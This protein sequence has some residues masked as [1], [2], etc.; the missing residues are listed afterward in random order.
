MLQLA[1]KDGLCINCLKWGHF[2]KNCMKGPCGE[3][4]VSE[5]T[6]P[7]A[8]L[9]ERVRG[10]GVPRDRDPKGRKE[11]TWGLPREKDSDLSASLVNPKNGLVDVK[12]DTKKET[13][14]EEIETLNNNLIDKTVYVTNPTNTTKIVKAYVCFF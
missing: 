8:A 13:K 9:E 14:S 7:V 11:Q 3:M 10:R 2:V 1:K 12:K 4:W 5:E 6:S